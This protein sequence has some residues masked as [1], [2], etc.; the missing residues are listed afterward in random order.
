MASGTTTLEALLLKRPMVI[1]YR[2]AGL[3]FWLMKKMAKIQYV[4]LPNLLAGRALV[5]ELLQDDATVESLSLSVQRYLSSPEA[6]QELLGQYH[7]IHLAL[8]KNANQ[9]AAEAVIDLWSSPASN[10]K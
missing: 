7:K 8:R 1:A 5:P 3:S 6:T 10:N 4:G 9:R 2:M